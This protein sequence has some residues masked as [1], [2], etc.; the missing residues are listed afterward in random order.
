[1]SYHFCWHRRRTKTNKGM[2][3]IT[4]YL[5]EVVLTAVGV[6]VGLVL[7]GYIQKWLAPKA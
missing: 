6:A 5:P 4:S 3:K 1:M 2:N 7:A